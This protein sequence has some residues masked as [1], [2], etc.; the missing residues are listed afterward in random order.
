MDDSRHCKIIVFPFALAHNAS[1]ILIHLL[2]AHRMDTEEFCCSSGVGEK[3]TK[4]FD[5]VS[6]LWIAL[7]VEK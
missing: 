5:G 7:G 3:N 4:A 6:K 2:Y 1:V